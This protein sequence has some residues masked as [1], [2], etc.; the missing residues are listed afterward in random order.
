MTAFIDFK[1]IFA[2]YQQTIM[3][4]L[5]NTKTKSGYDIYIRLKILDTLPSRSKYS[6]ILSFSS[7]DYSFRILV[8]E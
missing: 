2:I 1:Q 5:E 3:F 6:L 7:E 4:S 8:E